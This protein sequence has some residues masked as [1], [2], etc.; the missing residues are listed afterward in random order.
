MAPWSSEHS[1]RM[2]WTL[3][4]SSLGWGDRLVTKQFPCECQDLQS[5]SWVT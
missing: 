5:V 4:G 2:T 1:E 3:K